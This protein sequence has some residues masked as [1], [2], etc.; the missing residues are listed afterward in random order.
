MLSQILCVRL[1]PLQHSACLAHGALKFGN[2]DH[3][4]N[5]VVEQRIELWLTSQR[6]EN[7]DCVHAVHIYND[8]RVVFH[9]LP[10][11]IAIAIDGCICILRFL[12]GICM[13]LVTHAGL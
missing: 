8:F 9:C 6:I 3:D 5:A 10:Q 1:H 12:V 11:V 4:V 13:G 2:F 7:V